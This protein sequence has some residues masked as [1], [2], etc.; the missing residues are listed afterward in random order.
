MRHKAE[1][2][3]SERKRL[4]KSKILVFISKAN[5]FW[6]SQSIELVSLAIEWGGMHKSINFSFLQKEGL[7]PPAVQSKRFF[8]DLIT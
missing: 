6:R 5:F 3:F 8:G 7:I 1:I 4:Q 2:F